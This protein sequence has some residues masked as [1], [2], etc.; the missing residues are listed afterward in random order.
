ML[1]C[2]LSDCGAPAAALIHFKG[3]T[4]PIP[5]CSRH[6]FNRRGEPIFGRRENGVW[7]STVR[8]VE[9]VSRPPKGATP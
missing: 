3:L 1:L 8:H 9:R 7:V 2:D 5:Y 4:K 6:A